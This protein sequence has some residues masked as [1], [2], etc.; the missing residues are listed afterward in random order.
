MK[1]AVESD[2]EIRERIRT[3][4]RKNLYSDKGVAFAPWI[5]KQIDEDVS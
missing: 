2:E 5:T 4:M 3:K 1:M